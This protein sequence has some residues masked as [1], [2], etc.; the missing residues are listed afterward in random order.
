MQAD[1]GGTALLNAS[2]GS[3]TISAPIVLILMAAQMGGGTLT[4]NGGVSGTGGLSVS[5]GVLTLTTSNNTY[6]GPTTAGTA[7]TLALLN[8]NAFPNSTLTMSGG[9]VVFDSSVSPKVFNIGGLAGTS[10][11][12]LQDNAASPNPVTLN[13]GGNGAVTNYTG[14]LSGAGTLNVVGPGTL[15]LG[16]A[17]AAGNL[18][19]GI[20]ISGGELGVVTGALGT[21]HPAFA[22]GALQYAA[23]NTQ[24][25]G[26]LFTNNTFPI[27]LDTNGGTVPVSN[28]GSTNSGGL[29]KLGSGLLELSGNN[30][31]SG[32]TTISGGTL[33]MGILPGG[34]GFLP[35]LTAVNLSSSSAYLN[36]GATPQTIGSLTGVSAA[37]VLDGVSLTTGND[38]T[39]ATFSGM[40]TGTGSLTKIGL[41]TAVLNGPNGYTGAT[42]VSGGTLAV[43]PSGSLPAT[44]TLTDNAS[45]SFNNSSQSLFALASSGSVTLNNTALTITGTS[46]FS[47]SING[48]GSLL[49]SGGSLTLIG[50]NASA[51]PTTVNNGTLVLSNAGSNNIAA[52]TP[53]TVNSLGTLNVSGLGAGNGITLA[54]EQTLRGQ[55]NVLGSVT[56]GTGST[57]LS[58]TGNT[59]GTGIGTLTLMGNLNF[60]SGATLATYLGTP[61]TSS[62]SPGD[63]GLI[64]VQGNVTLP[65]SGLNLSLLTNSNLAGLGSLGNGYY[66]LI[67]YTGTLTGAPSSAFAPVSGRTFAFYVQNNQLDMY[68]AIANLNWTGVNSAGAAN[69]SWDTTTTSTNWAN[70]ALS[71]TTANSYQDGSNVTFQDK[72]VLT[73]GTIANSNIVIQPGGV[74]PNALTI[75]NNAVSYTFSDAAGGTVGIAGLTGIV[76]SGSGAVYLQGANSFQ[77]PVTINGG[78][79]N[80]ANSAGLGN[81]SGVTVAS[82]AALQLQGGVAVPAISLSLAGS[83][84]TGSPGALN[85][86]S[87]T[88]SY[89]GAVTLTG[90]STIDAT[91]G[92][93]T[94]GGA[95]NNGGYLL[96]IGGSGTTTMSGPGI[97]GTGGLTVN[98]RATLNLSGSLA[99]SVN[100]IDNGALNLSTA[101]QSV[102]NFSGSG[103]GSSLILNNTALTVTGTGVFAGSIS[104]GGSLA[105]S[106]V[107]QL[108]GADRAGRRR[109]RQRHLA[110]RGHRFGLVGQQSGRRLPVRCGWRRVP[111][112]RS[113]LRDRQR[114]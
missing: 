19:G 53:V 81:S 97:S 36:L 21:M 35:S 99:S 63:G 17:G 13:V 71:S 52:A 74:Q 44:T 83:G 70:L 113:S 56:A 100:V 80:V 110:R 5:N 109:G 101:A 47:G 51:V 14:L 86:V 43:G 48:G 84:V 87:G 8:S 95:V 10:N 18:T 24:D 58:G 28:I 102:A 11:L 3:H 77:G 7:G 89:A 106:G 40:I 55:G 78:I 79:V 64:N 25:Y 68:V 107:Q 4:L 65:S 108:T 111:E 42:S 49:A 67:N 20:R 98:A 12:A 6:T 33:Q 38:N 2:D 93:L 54:S 104:G 90:S 9:A 60:A 31:Y 72:N 45:V 27:A 88:N 16:I 82:G 26:S 62:T 39:N 15:V 57:L 29:T 37:T 46:T 50:N 94:L 34:T 23:S 22:G 61:G 96:T 59:V 91:A 69:S 105:I 73:G 92:L 114:Q 41:G 112:R 76:K 30:T 85:S 75:N 66:D 103:A 32:P 1:V